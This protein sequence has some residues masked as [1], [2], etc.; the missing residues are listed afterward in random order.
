LKPSFGRFD[1]VLSRLASRALLPLRRLLRRPLRLQNVN[2]NERPTKDSRAHF[3]DF[4][5]LLRFDGID[6]TL[7]STRLVTEE[8]LVIASL[9]ASASKRSF[10]STS[11]L[12]SCNSEKF[13][14]FVEIEENLDGS[15]RSSHVV[16]SWS[17]FDKQNLNSA[18]VA[19]I[20]ARLE[21]LIC[22]YQ[23]NNN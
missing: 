1:L 12:Q 10:S 13:Y 19:H 22:N 5:G 21:L 4:L 18:K 23:I 9:K 16:L 15:S 6:L 20:A 8:L 7:M 14:G 2:G 17:L 3:L 11:S